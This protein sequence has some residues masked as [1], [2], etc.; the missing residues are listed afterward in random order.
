VDPGG[1]GGGG[2][3][4]TGLFC[5]SC[6]AQSSPTAKFC[7]ECG[8]RLSQATRSAEYKQVTVLFADV[9]HSMDIAAAVGAERLRE[10]MADL[11]NRCAA[12][13]QRF[14]GT[15][16]QFTG[17]GIMAV[18]GAPV[19]LEDHAI[20]ACLAALGIQEE[21][22]RLAIDVHDRDGVELRL[23]VGL[24]SG[25]VIAGEIGSGAWGYTTIGEQVGMAQ[26][27]ESV[28]PPGEMMLSESTA[29]LVDGAAALGQPEMVC[30]KGARQPV[31]AQRLLGMQDQHRAAVRAESNLVGRRRELSAVE[32]LLGRAVEGHGA[33][34]GVVG[35]P[36]I[37]KSRLVR[38][39]SA[40]AAT[41]GVEVFTAFCESHESQVPFHA[42]ARLLRA[43]TGVE[44]LDPQAAR[45]RTR[46]KSPDA[47]AEDLLLLDD[48]LGI[49][50]PDV[51]L[52]RIDPDARRRR[53]TALVNTALS[54]RE[55]PALYIIEDAHWI[56]EVS[57]SMLTEFLVVIA[58]SPS[59]VL[60]TYRP[61]YR[62]ALSRVAGAQTI[63]LASLSDSETTALVT[64]LLGADP[65]V[66]ALGQTIADRA[67]GNPFFAE[68]IV[69]ELA[70]RG[71]LRGEPGAYLST[72][73]AAEATVPATLQATIAARIDRLDPKA[74]RTL[75]AAAVIGSRFGLDLLTSLGVEP[76]VSDLV[77]A[78]LVDQVTFTRQA[79]YVFHHPLIRAVAYESQLKS[80]RAEMH[81][82]LAATIEGRDPESADENAAL[83]AEHLEAAGDLHAAYGWHMR[84]GSWSAN[85]DV[86][87]AQMSWQRA[88]QVTD[89]LPDDDPDRIAMHIA[90][91]TRLCR[92][93][94]RVH[95][96][97]SGGLFEELRQ[98]CAAAGDKRSLAIGMAGLVE[99]HMMYGRL[100]EASRMASETMAL[101]ESIG[102]PTLTVGLSM[103]PIAAKLHTGEI[104]V[105]LRWSQTVIDLA[106]REP[107]KRDSIIDWRLTVSL[108]HALATRGSA[109]CAL[110]DR[111]WRSDLDQAVAKARSIG[112][113]PYATII[114]YSYGLAIG[115]GV[116][117]A[118]DA[119]LRD[120]EE[121][122][123]IAERASDDLALG[124]ARFTLGIALVHRDSPAER[125]RAPEVLG[126]VRD[127]CLHG[128]LYL[129]M[130]AVVDM[131]TARERARRGDRDGAIPLLREAVD[132]LF[133]E[134][135]LS[136]CI[137]ATAFLVETLLDRGANGDVPDA[138][139]AIE[140]L[141]V[142]PADEG[143]VIRDIWL[144]R[145]RAL[146]ARAR[147]DEATY[148]DYRD[149]YRAMARTLGFE[150]HIA[151]AEAMP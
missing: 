119:A 89:A 122:L 76:V 151:W 66:G 23:R 137:A 112:P 65:S 70:E 59:L 60:V 90:A 54:A 144:R 79:E 150:G 115:S 16:N 64:E 146:L 55:A 120:I 12:V 69:R 67:G 127:M 81:R 5:G 32:G 139:A 61:E 33:V 113:L 26:R 80:D 134:R 13:V 63:V 41:R 123:R 35:P 58:Q 37:G 51:V 142:A 72:T 88:R 2:L 83:I 129:F 128:R 118:D 96:D 116:L 84:A 62:G 71:A 138:E 68:E 133:H 18:F 77:A 50:D 48:L 73:D 91:R 111:G 92:H 19:A 85:R 97:V 21:A 46:A 87:A 27:M 126:Q 131:C 75:G 98:L 9:V 49:A 3:T 135:Q 121:A 136:S 108:A 8:T 53:L 143:L 24:N 93:A 34:V 102:D 101:V 114:S 82:R 25:Q 107:T 44:G 28:A 117:L 106:D 105:A 94:F 1:D 104:G 39:V 100:G 36:G 30:I 140:R 109:R 4:A 43:A 15:V 56:D 45:A 29:R 7:G 103:S 141:A 47:E 10:I 110:G 52:P 86:V 6:G 148:R 95:V 125:D 145:L 31:A 17:D 14:G 130:L 99:V 57:E 149:R 40:M 11:V 78:Q 124:L 74:K 38:E 147:G 22:M 20:R 42:V 132:N